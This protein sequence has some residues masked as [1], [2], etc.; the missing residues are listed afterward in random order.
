M[1]KKK[2]KEAD[3]EKVEAPAAK[4]KAKNRVKK[5]DQLLN[6]VYQAMDLIIIK[7]ALNIT[8]GNKTAVSD[9]LGIS[10]MTLNKKIESLRINV[11]PYKKG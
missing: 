11:E 4:S 8:K 3:K 10:R 2:K 6:R 1:S 5:G 9:L 7:E